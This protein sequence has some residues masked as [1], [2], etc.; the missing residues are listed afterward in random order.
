MSQEVSNNT[1][2]STVESQKQVDSITKATIENQQLV[3]GD[4]S[5]EIPNSEGNTNSFARSEDSNSDIIISSSNNSNASNQ[6]SEQDLL[7]TLRKD[8]KKE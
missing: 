5:S 3:S 6:V 4:S 7:L 2:N 8:F 1:E